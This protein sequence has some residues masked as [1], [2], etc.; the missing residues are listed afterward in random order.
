MKLEPTPITEPQQKKILKA[1]AYSFGSGFVGGFSL[2][3]TGLLT[4][5][6]NGGQLNLTASLGMGLVLGG[7]VGGINAAAVTV[8]QIFTPEQ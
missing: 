4:S 1:L 6:M 2:A 5:I 3:I 8:K 7:V